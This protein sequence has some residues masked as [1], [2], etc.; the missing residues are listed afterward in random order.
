MGDGGHN[1]TAARRSFGGLSTGGTGGCRVRQQEMKRES[2]RGGE[3]EATCKMPRQA[4]WAAGTAGSLV[5]QVSMHKKG[6]GGAIDQSGRASE[7]AWGRCIGGCERVQVASRQNS[8]SSR[9]HRIVPAGLDALLRSELPERVARGR[10]NGPVDDLDEVECSV[11]P[12]PPPPPPGTRR[13]PGQG[14]GVDFSGI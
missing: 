8:P 4:D 12:P 10:T 2:D 11:P 3:E 9:C 13:F 14:N 7:R 1:V 6:D 5:A